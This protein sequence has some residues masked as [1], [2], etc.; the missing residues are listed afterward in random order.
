MATHQQSHLKVICVELQKK[1]VMCMTGVMCL[2]STTAHTDGKNW[3]HGTGKPTFLT[4][5]EKQNAR[6]GYMTRATSFPMP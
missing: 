2:N 4:I 6:D 3:L 5:Q 1:A